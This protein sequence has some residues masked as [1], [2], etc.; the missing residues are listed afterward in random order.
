LD[1][2]VVESA[3][4]KLLRRFATP[5]EDLDAKRAQLTKGLQH[6]EKAIR[7]LN[8]AI[9]AG[10]GDA[11]VSL[12]DELRDRE[13]VQKALLAKLTSLTEAPTLTPEVVSKIRDDAMAAERLA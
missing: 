8:A 7:N 5:R 1:P 2:K 6:A 11:P 3:L 10:D 13:R 9:V 12:V 4:D